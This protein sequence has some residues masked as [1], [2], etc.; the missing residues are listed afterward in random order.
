MHSG[1]V[2]KDKP[3]DPFEYTA[4]N[5]GYLRA[6][7]GGWS[8]N[9]SRRKE[10]GFTNK[11]FSKTGS[12]QVSGSHITGEQR[13]YTAVAVIEIAQQITVNSTQFRD[14]PVTVDIEGVGEESQVV[15]ICSW[16]Q[17]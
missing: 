4:K 14:L 16:I 5:V 12:D 11:I 8:Y 10:D 7:Q 15:Q 2:I 9:D 6:G 3:E 17:I 1:I 13:S